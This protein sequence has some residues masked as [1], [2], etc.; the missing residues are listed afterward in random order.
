MSM[1]ELLEQDKERLLEELKAAR[2]PTDAVKAL[3]NE[4]DRLYRYNEDCRSDRGRE[5]A[6]GMMQTAR[7]AAPFCD[8]VMDARVWNRH[9]PDKKHGILPTGKGLALF[10]AGIVCLAAGALLPWLR[11][12]PGSMMLWCILLCAAGGVLLYIAGHLTGKPERKQ[13]EDIMTEIVLDPQRLYRVYRAMILNVDQNLERQLSQSR[14]EEKNKLFQGPGEEIPED[15]ISL[16]SEL[17]E[18]AYSEDGAYALEKLQDI[19]YYLHCHQIETVEYS[20]ETKEWFDLMPAEHTGTIR[21]ALVK[22]G[23]LLQRGRASGGIS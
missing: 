7:M 18:A 9:M 20:Q 21:P 14:F 3:E 1:L 11:E 16:F 2:M 4:S 17:L 19:R 23:R 5:A 13:N 12:V 22:N 10:I 15:E 6:S 8:S